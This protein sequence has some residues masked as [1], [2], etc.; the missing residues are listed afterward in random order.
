MV[1]AAAPF[2]VTIVDALKE[3]SELYTYGLSPFWFIYQPTFQHVSFLFTDTPFVR[4]CL[5]TLLVGLLTVAITLALALPA[6]YSLARLRLRFGGGLAVA[7]FLVYLVPPSLLFIS[8]SQV[9]AFLGLQDTVWSMVVIYP[10]VTTPVAV[11]LLLGFFKA[12]PVDIEEQ[13]MVDGYSRAQ[14]FLRVL[15]PLAYP[16]IVAV[17]IFAF[18]LAAGD[19]IYALAFVSAS[20]AKTVSIGVPT[21]LVRGDVFFWQSLLASVVIVALPIAVV[22]NMFLNRFIAGFT[23][24]SVKG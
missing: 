15:L 7:I 5:N 23:Q 3:D 24:G 21:E 9:V 19:F 6:A 1:F 12:I 16:G 20:E 10:T 4:F 22:F 14:A 8:M 18:T 17:V 2:E 11:W 13:A